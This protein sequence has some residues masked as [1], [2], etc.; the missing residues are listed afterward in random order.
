[1]GALSLVLLGA[2]PSTALL[3][4]NDRGFLDS[5]GLIFNPYLGPRNC[6]VCVQTSWKGSCATLAQAFGVAPPQ[7]FLPFH[8]ELPQRLGKEQGRRLLFPSEGEMAALPSQVSPRR[9]RQPWI[10]C[11]SQCEPDNW[12]Q[13]SGLG[14]DAKLEV[15]LLG[16]ASCK[17]VCVHVCA[18]SD[19]TSLSTCVHMCITTCI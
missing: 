18:C 14:W 2:I 12:R 5:Q 1:M 6:P 13:I 16:L 4:P 17:C 10:S 11:C 3:A 15:Q 19:S 7:C 8:P 9:Q